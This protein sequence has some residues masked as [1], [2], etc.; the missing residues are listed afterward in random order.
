MGRFG[1]LFAIAQG[2]EKSKFRVVEMPRK[3]DATSSDGELLSSGETV[4]R[5]GIYEVLH[6]PHHQ[7][8]S[9]NTVVAL[10]GEMLQPCNVCGGDVRFRLIYEAQHVSEDPDFARQ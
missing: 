5:S 1:K 2:M 7:G 10:R 4:E 9:G 8:T 3:L 6:A